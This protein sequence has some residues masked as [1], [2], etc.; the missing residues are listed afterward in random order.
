MPQLRSGSLPEKFRGSDRLT[1]KIR[2]ASTVFTRSR[3]APGQ[4]AT[5]PDVIQDAGSFVISAGTGP[6][7]PLS[8]GSST[9]RL[10]MTIALPGAR[11]DPLATPPSGSLRPGRGA[12]ATAGYYVLQFGGVITDEWIRSL[13]NAGIEVIQYVP[14]QALFVYGDEDAIA[15][16]ADHSRVRWIGRYLPEQKLSA[17]FREQLSAARGGTFARGAGPIDVDKDGRAVFDI[18]V[19]K[20]TNVRDVADDIAEAYGARDIVVSELRRSFFNVIRASVSLDRI[21]S[22]ADVPDVFSIEPVSPTK[23]EDEVAA[24]ILAGRYA[25]PTAL[26]GPGY[27]PLNLFG[28][29]GTGITVSVVDDGV[30]IPGDGGYYITAAKAVDGPLHNTTS[31]AS[32]HGHLNATII[33]GG[34]P[35]SATDLYGYNYGIGVAPGAHIVNI[36]RNRPGYNGTDVEVYNDCVTT[37]GPN[38]VAGVISNN[39]WGQ[40]T[41]GNT[42]GL[43]EAKFDGFVLDASIDTTIDPVAMIFSAGNDAANGLTRPKMAKNVIAVGASESLRSDLGGPLANNIDEMAPTSSR[44]PAADGRIK[45]DVV[46]PGTAITGGRSGGDSLS[47]NLN[48]AV[49]WNSGTSHAA[50]NI[51]GAAA[52]FAHKWYL[53]NFGFRAKPSLIKAALVNSTVDLNG[54][55]TGTPIPNGLEGWGRPNLQSMLTPGVGTK[56]INEQVALQNVGDN[57]PISGSVASSSKPVRITLAWS[58]PPGVTDP[59]LVNDLDLQ[60]TVGS[61]VYLGNVIQ[62]GVSVTGGNFDRRN[63]VE[64]VILP[65]GIQAGTPISVAVIASALNGDGILDNGDFTDQYYSLAISNYSAAVTPQFHSIVGRALSP[66]GR[67]VGMVVVRLM[68]S[69]GGVQ[70]RLTNPFGYFRFADVSG[71]QYISLTATSKRYTFSTQQIFLSSNLAD[72]VLPASGGKP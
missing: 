51:S 17:A 14:G 7:K 54:S 58:D 50:A 6:S 70:E 24:Q 16:A 2:A 53:D 8:D 21:A 43:M 15:A 3:K 37:V 40:G 13:T 22:I 18:A 32:G 27:D 60:V 36:P 5:G 25:G 59:S 9:E 10:D 46:A 33:A 19:F 49:R 12:G 66:S 1:K 20:H 55:N 62:N 69:H 47:G 38:G 35:Y 72:V 48:S 31:G 41:N 29:D 4:T 11:F 64:T 39:S 68:D 52:L 67:G 30:G 57:F 28:A 45:P 63:T 56:Y 23:A 44:G 42:Y 34:P 26:L 71:G 61:S 65:A